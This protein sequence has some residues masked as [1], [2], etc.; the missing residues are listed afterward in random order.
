MKKIS[1]INLNELINKG[2]DN[3]NEEEKMLLSL[4]GAIQKYKTCKKE[5]K[6]FYEYF[7]SATYEALKENYNYIW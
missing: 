1:N 5:E 4:K 7:I 6:N 3:L 2:Y